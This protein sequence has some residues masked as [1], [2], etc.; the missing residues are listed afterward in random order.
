MWVPVFAL[1]LLAPWAAECSWGGFAPADVP[2]VVVVLAPMYGGAA[3]LIREVARRTGGGWPAIVLLAAA[4]GW[5]QAGLVD[6]SLFNPRFLDDTEFAGLE[7]AAAGTRVPGLGFSAEQLLAYVGNHVALS[8]CAPI[9]VVESFVGRERRGR[10]WLGGAG[11]AVMGVVY[12]LGS[13]AVFADDQGRKG[14]LASPVQ[15][16]GTVL[17]VLVLVAAAL[18][19][20][21]GP[22]GDGRPAPRAVWAGVVTGVAGFSAGWAPGWAGVA[23]QTAA[24]A[25]A[26]VLVLWWSRRA[27]WGQ[28]HVLAAAA[29]FLVAA[30]AGAY[31]APNYA[32]ASPAVAVA[33]DVTGSVITVV[34]LAAAF[35]R[36]GR[37]RVPGRAAVG[38]RAPAGGE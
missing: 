25:S 24:L 20:R 23:V 32:P 2:F 21:R 34:L 27:G 14:F 9:A 7:A 18:L 17:V 16:G 26:G 3:V 30:S 1:L 37:E 15:L 28:R 6:Q 22:A 29:G 8:I 13:C 19:V 12:V 36:V 4:F 11:L 10:P 33:S 5:V 31:L 35:V 38:R